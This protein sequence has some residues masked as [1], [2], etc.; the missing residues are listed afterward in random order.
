MKWLKKHIKYVYV[1]GISKLQ[2]ESIKNEK[3]DTNKP[4]DT[5]WLGYY[6]KDATCYKV[7]VSFK[8][9]KI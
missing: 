3:Y 9:K 7:I 4:N 8:K 1:N 5:I 6:I 2:F